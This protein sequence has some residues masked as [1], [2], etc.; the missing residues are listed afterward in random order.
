M[1]FWMI[2]GPTVF[3]YYW[4]SNI[5]LYFSNGGGKEPNPFDE[6]SEERDKE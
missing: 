2:E 1:M 4:C 5:V 3:Q 6:E